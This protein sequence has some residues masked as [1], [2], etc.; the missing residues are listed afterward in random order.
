MSS[1]RW[2]SGV[3]ATLLLGSLGSGCAQGEL[4]G[5]YFALTLR[6][7]ENL[8][9]GNGT[10]YTDN[11]EYR[12]EVDGNDV[13]V[14]IG[15][16]IWA[17]GLVDGCTVSYTS[18]AWSDYRDDGQGNSLEIQWQINGEARVNLGGG[19]GCVEKDDWEGTE[20]FVITE[21]A[22]PDVQ[23]GCTYTLDAVGKWEKE[24]L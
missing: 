16:D 13:S 6:G 22:H 14:A 18:L 12:L 7:A 21:S 5:Q 2:I 8:C 19:G 4:P 23:A 24:V 10:G 9:T 3:A 1:K 11:F 15:E 17:T 20:T